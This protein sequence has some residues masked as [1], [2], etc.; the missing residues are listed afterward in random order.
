MSAV[1]KPTESAIETLRLETSAVSETAG[2]DQNQDVAI[3]VPVGTAGSER[4]EYLLAVADGMGGHPAGDVASRIAVDAL[5]AALE[6]FPEGDIGLAMK[7]AFRKANEAVYQAAVSE[8]DHKGMG[9][10]LTSALL[11]GKYATIANVG[12]SRAYLLRGGGLT[13]VSRDH[14]AVA[15]DV[16]AGRSTPQAARRDP[17]RNILTHVIGTDAKL[18]S[19]LPDVFEVML[20][21]GDRL[22][23]CSDGLYDVLDDV[24]IQRTLLGADTGTAARQLVSLAQQRGTSDNA[25][26]VVAA[27]VPT[28]VPVVTIPAPVSRTGGIPGTVIA[29]A[30]AVL[31][32]LL[33]LLAIFILGFA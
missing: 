2:R 23:L 1:A 15:A 33:T 28:R 31:L 9:T 22:L 24:D 20:L 18:D 21:P 30:V 7:Q 12:D 3:A 11:R 19:K 25:S 26:A 4:D 16:A 5:R 10:T 27:A 13:Q 8:P 14:T 17:R 32:I 29:A 6:K